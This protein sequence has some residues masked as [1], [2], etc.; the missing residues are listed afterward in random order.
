MCG[1]ADQEGTSASVSFGDLR[2]H[3]PALYRVDVDGQFPVSHRISD[4]APTIV[5][6]EV[7]ETLNWRKVGNLEDEVTG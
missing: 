1:V 7:L 4:S 6:G 5:G 2:R 3:G